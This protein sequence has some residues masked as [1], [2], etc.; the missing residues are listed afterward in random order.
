[1]RKEIKE[2]IIKKVIPAKY[3]DDETIYHVCCPTSK[4]NDLH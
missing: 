1:L 3:L 4:N 2:K